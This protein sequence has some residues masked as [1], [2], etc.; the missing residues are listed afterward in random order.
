MGHPG[1]FD[2]RRRQWID[3]DAASA[4]EIAAVVER[5]PSGALRYER[6]DGGPAEQP[7][8]ELSVQAMPDGPL[9]VRSDL[10]I[11]D[12]GGGTIRDLPRAALCRCGQSANKPF[13]DNTHRTSG[14]RAP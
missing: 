2:V 3:V 11:V 4:D 7:A 6:F 14:F 5:C 10:H 12:A 8:A 9:W 13:C 1:V